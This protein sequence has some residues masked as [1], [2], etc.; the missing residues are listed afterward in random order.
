MKSNPRITFDLY[1][2]TLTTQFC[3]QGKDILQKICS[4][5]GTV[6]YVKGTF[7]S[8]KGTFFR[9]DIGAFGNDRSAGRAAYFSGRPFCFI[10]ASICA[11]V[12][13]LFSLDIL[14]ALLSRERT[15]DT[16]Y[17][18]NRQRYRICSLLLLALP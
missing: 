15:L 4:V 16:Y 13:I 1:S 8:V 2:S 11:Q 18:A 10:S 9:D 17:G 7:F 3:L 5:K 12:C 14:S 6:F